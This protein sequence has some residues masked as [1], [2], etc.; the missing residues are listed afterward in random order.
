[1][2][3]IP[4]TKREFRFEELDS[5]T[6][7]GREY[8]FDEIYKMAYFSAFSKIQ[9]TPSPTRIQILSAAKMKNGLIDKNLGT[10]RA[11]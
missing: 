4:K 9:E 5:L 7:A 2:R 6:S 10:D 3:K 11:S 8:V 1:M